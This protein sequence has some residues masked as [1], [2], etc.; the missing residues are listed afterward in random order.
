MLTLAHIC[1]RDDRCL[2]QLFHECGP[3]TLVIDR[4]AWPANHEARA[5]ERR[6]LDDD[7]TAHAP[8]RLGD[9]RQTETGTALIA[10]PGI[11]EP[12]EAFEHPGAVGRP[13]LSDT[14]EHRAAVCRDSEVTT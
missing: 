13:A 7:R 14:L 3:D 2:N 6:I 5:S 9:D 8:N 1:Q 12:G 4:G 10:G 11:V